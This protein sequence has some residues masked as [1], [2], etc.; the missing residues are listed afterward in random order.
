MGTSLVS[1]SLPVANSN[2]VNRLFSATKI[3]SYVST[4]E[5]KYPLKYHTLLSSFSV[6]CRFS[7]SILQLFPFTNT[8]VSNTKSG[9]LIDK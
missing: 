7:N 1:K 2:S 5:M 3:N 6:L 9:Y 4:S 8:L